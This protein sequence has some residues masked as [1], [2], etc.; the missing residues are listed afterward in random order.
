MPKHRALETRTGKVNLKIPKLH[1]G[2]GA[3]P[4]GML[5]S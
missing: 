4:G 2:P 1:S 3:R 5:T